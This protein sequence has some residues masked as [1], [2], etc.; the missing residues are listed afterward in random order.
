MTLRVLVVDDDPAM[1]R[2]LGRLLSLGADVSVA[3]SRDH[4]ERLLA[5]APDG[6]RAYDLILSDVDLGVD[7]GPA[8]AAELRPALL[9]GVIFMTA[10][11]EDGRWAAALERLGRPVLR[12]PFTADEFF[13]LAERV[14][15]SRATVSRP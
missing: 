3:A 12:K 15:T 9:D 7:D 11:P 10:E 14:M 4:A 13:D 6:E 2:A 8:F 5:A 1:R